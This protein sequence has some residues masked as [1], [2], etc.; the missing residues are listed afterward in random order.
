MVRY[1]APNAPA[2]LSGLL[3]SFLY[4]HEARKI[5]IITNATGVTENIISRCAGMGLPL[6]V[7][8]CENGTSPARIEQTLNMISGIFIEG[9]P[10]WAGVCN[11]VCL[12][13]KMEKYSLNI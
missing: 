5:A 8:N 10:S 2:M 11:T 7:T 13:Q 6:K 9:V 3:F 1:A 4:N 12:F